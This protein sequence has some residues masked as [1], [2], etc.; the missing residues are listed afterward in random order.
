MNKTKFKLF[1]SVLLSGSIIIA[2][3]AEPAYGIKTERNIPYVENGH[4]NQVM[5]IYLPEQPSDKPLP[6][7]I[8]IHG[9]AWMAGTQANPP[10]LYLLNEGFA[11]ASIQHRFSSQAVWPAQ[12]YDCKAAVRFLRA[13][14]TEYNLDLNHFGI[15]GDSSGGHL[16]AF[17]GTSGDVSEMEGDLGNMNVSSRVQAVVDWFGPTDITLMAQQSGPGSFIRHDSPNSPES[18]LLGGLVQEKLGLAQ[19]ANPLT[20]I[21]KNDPPFLI[22]HGDNDQ[23]VP[24]GQSVILA[25]ALIDAGVEEVTM[26]TIHGAGHEGPEFRSAESRQLIKE[27]LTRKLKAAG[28]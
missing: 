14:A 19:T 6:L 13:H 21:D 28:N 20:Y 17:V 24:L 27:F 22:M 16:A 26:K 3:A 7:M 25:E 2:S 10:V 1:A 9:G 11:V 12:S 5:D 18:L 23:L 4:R 15:G 8:W